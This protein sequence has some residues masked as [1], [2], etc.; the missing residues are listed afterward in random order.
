MVISLIPTYYPFYMT[1]S[2]VE[3]SIIRFLLFC[4]TLKD[5]GDFIYI[6]IAQHV[7]RQFITDT[8]SNRPGKGAWNFQSIYHTAKFAV[9]RNTKQWQHSEECMCR[10]RNI[11]MRDYQESVPTGRTDRRRTKWS[12]Y[13]AILR[14]WHNKGMCKVYVQRN[15]DMILQSDEKSWSYGCAK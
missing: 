1:I 13:A 14:R 4:L 5:Y 9:N 6:A 10:L 8:R 12:L 3:L 11:A 15:S 7:L 2:S